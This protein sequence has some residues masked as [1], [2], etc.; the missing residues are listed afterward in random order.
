MVLSIS[1]LLTTQ[2]VKKSGSHLGKSEQFG[3]FLHPLKG[4]NYMCGFLGIKTISEHDV[5]CSVRKTGACYT[6]TVFYN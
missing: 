5:F 3:Q 1:G 4:I 6:Q 2:K